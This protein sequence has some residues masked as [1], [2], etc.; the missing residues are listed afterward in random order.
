MRNVI[1]LAMAL[2]STYSHA[3]PAILSEY[4]AQAKQANPAFNGFSA[5]RGKALYYRETVQNGKNISCA[6]CHS[7][8]PRQPGKT[9]AFRSIEPMATSV[10]PSRFSDNK[11]VEKWFRRNCDDVF[12]RECTALEKGDFLTYLSSVK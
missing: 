6:S 11:K 1:I 2:A 3:A 9:P 7:A 12:K 8:D 10:T 4:A 5:E